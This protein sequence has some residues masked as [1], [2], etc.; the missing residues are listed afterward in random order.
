MS[1][2]WFH[3]PRRD[4]LFL[5]GLVLYTVIF[6]LPWSYEIKIL[7]VTLLAWGAYLLHIL[8]PATAIWLILTSKSQ[9]VKINQSKS[10]NND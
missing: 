3:L 8:A 10:L 9:S 7:N 6:F 5:L 1:N 4:G 2:Q